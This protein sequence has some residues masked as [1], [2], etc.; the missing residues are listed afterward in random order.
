VLYAS[1]AMR[2]PVYLGVQ[3]AGG[4]RRGLMVYPF[5]MTRRETRNRPDDEVRGQLRY[6]AE[7]TWSAED[8]FVARDIAGVDTTLLL[9]V[10]P[11][12][13]LLLG[14]D[15]ALYDPLPLGI[16]VYAK[17][18]QVKAVTQDSWTVWERANHAGSRRAAPRAG[19]GLE[20]LVGF[21]PRRLLDYARFERSASALGLDPP[22]RHAAAIDAAKQ[23]RQGASA[24][25][26][27]HSLEANFDLSARE[28]LDIIQTRMRLEVAVKGGVAEHHLERLLRAD[29]L[30]ADVERLDQDAQPDF[31]VRLHDGAEVL[32]ECKNASPE[33]FANG[34]MKVE[35]Q[36]TRATRDD[37][38]GRLYRPDQFDVVAACLYSP[39]RSWEFR[40]IRAA[41]LAR[42]AAHTDRLAATHRIDGRWAATLRE[43]LTAS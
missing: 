37:P 33:R 34:D 15:P 13:G 1:E 38:A 3:D 10:Y 42:H 35:I 12:G 21:Q 26:P 2:V 8:H 25:R 41:R 43:A 24:D 30:L 19:E 39:M 36:K 23:P 27:P 16:S 4:E 31:R 18:T 9:G 28:I 40:F 5:R 32:I 22:L 20:T 7:E 11:E 6:G 17:D 29:P 14:L